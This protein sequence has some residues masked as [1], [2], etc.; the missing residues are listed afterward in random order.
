VGSAVI[1][2]VSSF[3]GFP[4]AVTRKKE[5]VDFLKR[6]GA[7]E[8]IL[9]SDGNY[10][11]SSLADVVV[12]NVGSFTFSSSLKAL[13]PS[14]RMILI[15]NLHIQPVQVKLGAIIVRSLKVLGSDSCPRGEFLSLLNFLRKKTIR[16]TIGEVFPLSRVKD[17]QNLLE[18]GKVVGRVVLDPWR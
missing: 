10:K 2:L 15:G 13:R 6:L 5:K 1:Q 4:V 3:G 12:E 14:G 7:V 9:T 8:V 18:E 17:A 11:F 16:P